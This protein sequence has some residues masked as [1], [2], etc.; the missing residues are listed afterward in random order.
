V[1]GQQVER[2][3]RETRAIRENKGYKGNLENKDRWGAA[4]TPI[5]FVFK[6]PKAFKASKA[7]PGEPALMA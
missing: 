1:T 5:L 2:D 4:S 7:F 3:Q 6:V